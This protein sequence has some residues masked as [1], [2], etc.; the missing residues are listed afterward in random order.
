MKKTKIGLGCLFFP[1]FQAEEYKI[2]ERS[3]ASMTTLAERMDFDLITS[4]VMISTEKQAIEAADYFK[5][6][7]PD[8]LLLQASSLIL[9]DI[10][11]PFA[12]ASER[13]GFWIVPEPVLEGALPLNSLTGFN[14]GVSILRKNYPDRLV[15]WFYGSPDGD[16][17]DFQERLKI[18]IRALR[19]IKNLNGSR[20]GLIHDVV[21]TFINLTFD[22]KELKSKL[23]VE[24]IKLPLDDVFNQTSNQKT[25]RETITI[26]KEMVTA[27]SRIDVPKIEITKSSGISSSLLKIAK[28]N[29]L[30]AIALRC[31]PEFQDVMKLA[32]CASV[33]YLNDHGLITSCE[34][35]LPGAVSMLV[36]WFISKEAPTM[37]D[38]V[39]LDFKNNLIQMW[40]C[41][42][43]P[44]S[45]ADEKGQTLDWHH[46]L[47]RRIPEEAKK[48]GLSSDISFKKGAVTLLHI[49]GN[50]SSIFVMEA[51]IVTGP[52]EP[53]PGSGGW[54]GKLSCNDTPVSIPDFL[55][56][57]SKYGLDHHYPVM[58]GHHEDTVRELAAW[59]DIRILDIPKS[60]KYVK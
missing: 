36:S 31:W 49:A 16:D 35:D 10:I 39:A 21:P 38:P 47:N 5:S 4:S 8:F 23:G 46:T 57:I 6:Q 12:E 15:K 51:E 48:L 13:I 37:N 28:E 53:Y 33:S 20:I 45:W 56:C 18:T 59:A 32:P 22:S 26:E 3:I 60:K 34:G 11:L 19:C 2:Y 55:E 43:G 58:R 24:V 27:A 17:P 41:G 50:G 7:K 14:L 29:H 54:I 52:A 40:H 42:P 44:V 30:D 1:N 25:D 9:G